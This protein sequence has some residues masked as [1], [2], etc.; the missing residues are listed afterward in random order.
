MRNR[1]ELDSLP[2][3]ARAIAPAPR[4]AWRHA[5]A[6]DPWAQVRPPGVQA[7][8]QIVHVLDLDGGFERVWSERFE[9]STRRAVRKAEKAGLELESDTTGRLVEVCHELY[10]RWLTGRANDRR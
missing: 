10:L 1:G 4:D 3:G 8:P 6:S 5:L 2:T 7:T 9:S